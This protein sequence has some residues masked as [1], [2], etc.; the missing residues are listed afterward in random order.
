VL[1]A[2]KVPQ[3]VYSKNGMIKLSGLLPEQ[4]SQIKSELTFNNPAYESTMRYS[5]WATT[6]VPPYLTYYRQIDDSTLFVPIGYDIESLRSRIIGDER[7]LSPANFPPFVL[8]LRP[9]QQIAAD[10]FIE[11]NK[12]PVLKGNIQMPTAKGKSILGLYLSHFLSQK[13][14]IVVHKDDLVSGWKAD[15][16]LA[17]AGKIKAGLI[18]AKSRKVGEQITIATIQTLNNFSEEEL[19]PL[20]S[21]FGLVI[22]DECHHVGAQTF[23]LTSRFNSRYK[24]GLTATP[25]RSDGLTHVIKLYFGDFCYTHIYNLNDNDI[26]PILVN[27]RS[28][29]AVYF[30]P[31]CKPTRNGG[32]AVS[33]KTAPKEY[34]LKEGE[35][36]IS[37]IPYNL[38]PKIFYSTIDRY[39]VSQILAENVVPDIV[40]EFDEGHSCIVFFKQKEDCESCYALLRNQIGEENVY[41]YYGN[42]KDNES[43]RER[44]ENQR[45]MVTVTTYA[46]ST[47]GTNVT[48]WEV[49][50]L[51]S[52][53]KDGKNVEQAVGRI[54]R[55]RKDGDKLRV[56]RVYDY[57]TPNVYTFASHGRSRDARYQKLMGGAVPPTPAVSLFGRGFSR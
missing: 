33:N 34:I 15:I 53:I 41:L 54:R 56:A 14:L 17:F 8:T 20:L 31:V 22:L 46:K 28:L 19:L 24:L 49:A 45:K 40:R 29:P 39:A 3:A 1:R 5:R 51:V 35:R 36:R 55:T 9:D 13:T 48:R 16:E 12:S 6:N 25:E 21:T 2:V 52:S 10:A 37:D 23:S 27:V 32:Y 26:L 30:N 43:V 7:I 38:R 50:F 11:Q 47:E 18:K 4:T 57:R 42:N 44:A